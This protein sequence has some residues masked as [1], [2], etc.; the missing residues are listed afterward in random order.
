MT[1][2]AFQSGN[3]QGN[4]NL[5]RNEVISYADGDF[6]QCCWT[7]QCCYLGENS[8]CIRRGRQESLLHKKQSRIFFNI[9]RN[10]QH[11]IPCCQAKKVRVKG[12]EGNK[13][14]SQNPNRKQVVFPT[15]IWEKTT[16]VFKVVLEIGILKYTQGHKYLYTA[17]LK[18]NHFLESRGHSLFDP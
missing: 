8:V 4:I 12:G 7:A 3:L 1:A 10:Y 14:P 17:I 13:T 2:T 18:K 6:A 9:E 15:Q 5:K 16:K 11:G